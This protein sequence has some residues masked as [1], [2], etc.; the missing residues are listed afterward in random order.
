MTFIFQRG[1]SLKGFCKEVY[2]IDISM[3][4][5]TETGLFNFVKHRSSCFYLIYF[6]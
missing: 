1:H 3:D 6:I 4:I 5:N 2:T